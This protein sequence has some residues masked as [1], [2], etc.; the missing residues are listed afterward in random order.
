MKAPHIPLQLAALAVIVVTN[1]VALSGAMLNRSGDAESQL[2]L[3][4]RELRLPYRSFD[5]ENSGLAL[6]LDWRVLVHPDKNVVYYSWEYS[7]GGMPEWLDK[8][9]M[10][11]LGFD[12]STVSEQAGRRNDRM[13]SREV[14][15]VLEFDGEA[16]RTSLE[17]ARQSLVTEE[18]KLA[19]L[20][21]S[22]D[23]KN[24]LKSIT[25][26]L[27]REENE[28][29]RLFVVDAGLSVETLRAKYADRT[30]YAIVRGQIR[31]WAGNGRGES[32][33]RGSISSVS[34]EA[35]NVP[36][37][38]RPLLADQ[39]EPGQGRFSASLSFGQRLEPWMTHL[40]VTPR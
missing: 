14:L 29:S 39:R 34:I 23:K 1:A 17:R 36:H 12:M 28:N 13:L 9:K 3:S 22:N 33:A 15:L 2:T 32:V 11:S 30:R 19:A 7:R 20:P 31:P 4:Q 37:A 40:E 21:D 35:I 16:Y 38:F 8:A 26:Q 6:S 25:D 24:R 10:E 18:E 5:R 27:T